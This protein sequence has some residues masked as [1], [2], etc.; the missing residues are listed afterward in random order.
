MRDREF[1][2]VSSRIAPDRDSWEGSTAQWISWIVL[3]DFDM[4]GSV[5]LVAP[6]YSCSPVYL[7]DGQGNFSINQ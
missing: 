2:D 4:D 7:N 3:R 1:A 5:D 6:D